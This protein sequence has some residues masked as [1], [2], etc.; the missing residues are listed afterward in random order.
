MTARISRALLALLAAGL[1]FGS[2]EQSRAQTYNQ[3]AFGMNWAAT[4]SPVCLMNGPNCR[5]QPFT[6]NL[7]TGAI[8]LTGATIQI[9]AAQTNAGQIGQ[10]TATYPGLGV[11]A[12][13]VRIAVNGFPVSDEYGINNP[14]T[15]AFVSALSV[16]AGAVTNAGQADFALAG[17]C[18]TANVNRGCVGTYGEG[19]ITVSGASAWGMNTVVVN[20]E[21]HSTTNCGQ[22]K[23]FDFAALQTEFDTT[24]FLKPGGVTPIGNAWGVQSIGFFQGQPTG[25]LTAFLV[26]ALD[27]TGTGHPIPWKVGLAT[28]SGTAQVGAS[29]GAV[30]NFGPSNSQGINLTA[31]DGS[32]NPLLTSLFENSIGA[33]QIDANANGGATVQLTGTYPNLNLIKTAA[34]GPAGMKL[35]NGATGVGVTSNLVL[36]TG[37]VNSNATFSVVDGAQLNITPGAGLPGGIAFNTAAATTT[38]GQSSNLFKIHDVASGLDTVSVGS[39]LGGWN[40]TTQSASFLNPTTNGLQTFS[41]GTSWPQGIRNLATENFV[42]QNSLGVQTIFVQNV[43]FALLDTSGAENGIFFISTRRAGSLVNKLAV[44][45]GVYA[46]ALTDPGQTAG[47]SNANFGAYQVN[48]TAGVTCGAGLS[49]SS[50]TI[51]GIVTT[52]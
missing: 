39:N 11:T 17:Y 51:N 27:M 33:F 28:D 13:L 16:P 2:S 6:I 31:L 37:A 26:E 12:D 3:L 8:G 32:S 42:G 18:N 10:F 40:F 48:N 21:N 15:Q 19:G 25:N 52:C 5:G 4:P 20:C 35:H 44:G 34:G 47:A 9:G 1:F 7:G 29:F 43:A 14:L 46:A 45:L 38:F 22:N 49:A 23:G 50:R 30:A 41:I 24:V 36:D